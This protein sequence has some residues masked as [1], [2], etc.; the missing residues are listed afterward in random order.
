MLDGPKLVDDIIFRRL[1]KC[2][3]E[4]KHYSYLLSCPYC[5][6][7]ALATYK[8]VGDRLEHKFMLVRYP[9]LNT[10]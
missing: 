4:G 1:E 7:H 2:F 10:I 8:Y 3:Q 6:I 9:P 5:G